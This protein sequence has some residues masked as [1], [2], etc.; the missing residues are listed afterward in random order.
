MI[1]G[2]GT[3][4]IEVNRI[5]DCLARHPKF[6]ERVFTDAETAYCLSHAGWAERLAGRFAAKEAIAKALGTRLR[7]RDVEV[8]PD[9]AGKPVVHLRNKAAEALGKGRVLVSISHCRT[10]AVAYAIVVSD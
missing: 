4:I 2:I 5:K 7:W 10:H 8:L 1:I 9:A 3:D 6:T